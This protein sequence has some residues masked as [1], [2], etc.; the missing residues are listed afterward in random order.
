[1]TSKEEVLIAQT[2]IEKDWRRCKERELQLFERLNAI[3][4]AFKEAYAAQLSYYPI[5]VSEEV[6]LKL[7]GEATDK[8]DNL[9][10]LCKAFI[11]KANEEAEE[12]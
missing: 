6:F 4:I 11:E 8:L 1:M 12:K 2:K 3:G 10:K 5:P 9:N 7:F